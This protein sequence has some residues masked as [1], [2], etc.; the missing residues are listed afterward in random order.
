MFSI[1]SQDNLRPK[2]FAR[3]TSR[4]YQSFGGILRDVNSSSLGG[5]GG[6]DY[7]TTMLYTW[8]PQ[9]VLLVGAR[10]I[11]YK[12]DA[13]EL[14]LTQTMRW[15][16]L[17]KEVENCHVKGKQPYECQ[18]YIKVLQQFKVQAQPYF[19]RNGEQDLANEVFLEPV[20]HRLPAAGQQVIRF[21]LLFF[22]TKL[23]NYRISCC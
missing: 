14:Q 23:Q 18:N 10:N 3:L 16:S 6:G 11:L 8:M 15:N 7:F 20:F 12:L 22:K 5:D 9:D 1:P 2:L 17:D 13:Q 4:D 21:L 19:S